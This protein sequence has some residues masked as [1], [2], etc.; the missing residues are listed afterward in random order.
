MNFIIR[1]VLAV[2]ILHIILSVFND[3]GN[4]WNNSTGVLTSSISVEEQK[5]QD[6]VYKEA[7][8][9]KEEKQDI[10][11]QGNTG[12]IPDVKPDLANI[13]INYSG[14]YIDRALNRGHL[15]RWNPETFPLKVYI[16]DNPELPDYFYKEVK[17]A[18]RAWEKASGNYFKFIYIT[19]ED[20]ADIRCKF[21]L[22]F[23][24]EFNSNVM[25][26]G[27]S[28][29]EISDKLIKYSE[30]EFA[31]YDKTNKYIKRKNLYR[32]AIHEIGH[33]LGI[34]GH[35]INPEDIMYP[36]S[37]RDKISKGD[38][39]TLRLLYSIIPD[40]S[41]R[42]FSREAKV[43]M[44]NADDI[45]GDYDR[46]IARELNYTIQDIEHSYGSK[47]KIIR[48]AELYF[49]QK[50]YEAAVKN[51]NKV[52]H[53]ISDTKLK[54]LVYYKIAL[55]YYNM[56]KYDEALNYAKQAY[57]LSNNPDMSPLI[58]KIYYDTGD[59]EQAKDF[60]KSILDSYPKT[61]NMYSILGK[62]Y[63]QEN[64]IDE[65]KILAQKAKQYFP[66]RPPITV[67]YTFK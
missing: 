32:T 21:P 60:A 65:L 39:N 37:T 51:Y 43:K 58:A 33:S 27:E 35:S 26:G 11:G 46:R 40:I 16:E 10:G 49:E 19:P 5:I 54:V 2:L 3:N 29:F 38:I 4:Q 66:E 41:N 12:F 67:K 64:N 7:N 44:A 53:K 28:R 47:S 59:Y 8:Q 50:N 15:V 55:S 31:V 48:I 36:V 22:N 17:K 25:K 63:E 13:D 34:S 14:N 61:Y 20:Y 18:F 24:R 52:L 1:F 56:S 57:N 9:K 45:L 62:I 30:I 23:D 6:T 42:E